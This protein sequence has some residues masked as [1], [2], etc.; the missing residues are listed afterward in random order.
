VSFRLILTI[1]FKVQ[2]S[3]LGLSKKRQDHGHEKY[4][5]NLGQ[6]AFKKGRT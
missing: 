4:Y 2:N 5:S 6:K 3:C 1:Y